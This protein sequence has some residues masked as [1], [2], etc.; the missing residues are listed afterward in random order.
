[1]VAVY[2]VWFDDVSMFDEHFDFFFFIFIFYKFLFVL[3]LPNLILS[4]VLDFYFVLSKSICF[5]VS[6]IVIGARVF[7]AFVSIFSIN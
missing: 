1:M 2:R 6:R 4:L 5:F 3:C 7:C